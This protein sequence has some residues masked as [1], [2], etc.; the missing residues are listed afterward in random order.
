MTAA[1]ESTSFEEEQLPNKRETITW[2]PRK[3]N[4]KILGQNK[5]DG[6]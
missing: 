2:K 6:E 5:A 4:P 1:I 3:G